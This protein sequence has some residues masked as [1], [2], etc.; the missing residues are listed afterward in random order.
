MLETK[1]S[2][3]EIVIT[4]CKKCPSFDRVLKR[5]PGIELSS[6]LVRTWLAYLIVAYSFLVQ[7][8]F[9]RIHESVS[10]TFLDIFCWIHWVTTSELHKRL[11]TMYSNRHHHQKIFLA[12]FWRHFRRVYS[13]WT[14]SVT[15]FDIFFFNYLSYTLGISL[16]RENDKSVNFITSKAYFQ[17]IKCFMDN[18]AYFVDHLINL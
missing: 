18:L 3:S 7:E 6:R 17:I 1:E 16:V 12:A 2:I 15:C 10:V 13:S 4:F 5:G 11:G 8:L 14:F 9:L